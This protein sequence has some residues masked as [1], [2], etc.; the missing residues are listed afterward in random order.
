MRVTGIFLIMLVTL[1]PVSAQLPSRFLLYDIKDGL[2]QNSVHAIFRDR[3]GL[4]WIGTQDGLNS[5]DGKNFT[6]YRHSDDDS[7]SISDQFVL[8]IQEDRS[9][10]IW[11]GT[12]NGLNAFNKRTKKFRRY[13]ADEKERHEFQSTYSDIFIQPD[14]NILIKKDGLYSLNTV[15]GQCRPLEINSLKNI[16]WLIAAAGKA[17]GLDASGNLYCN[18]NYATKE[19]TVSTLFTAPV[20]DLSSYNAKAY[21]DSLLFIYSGTKIFIYDTRHALIR[22]E[23]DL[24]FTCYSLTVTGPDEIYACGDKGI[25]LGGIN[26]ITEQISTRNANGNILPPGT[27]LSAFRDA[28]AD[29]WIGTSGNGIAVSN[30]SFNNYQLIRSP[31]PNDAVTAITKSGNQLYMGTRSGLYIISGSSKNISSLLKEK[32][33]TALTVDT[34]GNIWAGIQG[35]GIIVIGKTGNIIKKISTGNDPVKNVVMNLCVNSKGMIAA[36]TTGGFFFIDPDNGTISSPAEKLSGTYVMSAFED[37]GKNIWVANNNG[38]DEFAEAGKKKA[39]FISSDD[40]SSFIKRTIITSVTQDTAGAIW[41]GTIR[42]GIYKY[43]H[44]NFSHYTVSAGLA[45]D[46]V[47][48]VSCDGQNRIWATTSAGLDIFNASKNSFTTLSP[49]DGIPAS[50]FVF[51]AIYNDGDHIYFGTSEGMI[52]CNTNDIILHETGIEGICCRCKSERTKY[53]Y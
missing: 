1:V 41:I 14:G 8:N 4:V 18:K 21:G 49:A 10:T 40:K 29:L 43:E 25:C 30:K 17:W 53:Q 15:T 44:G 50:G 45:S 22:K 32:S 3:D 51:G 27:V 48:N 28:E 36:S 12:R 42:N 2:S 47:Y 23:I 6:V 9:G 20:T 16:N 13:Y 46:V 34:K 39:S 26:R 52:I 31:V 11:I 35:E 33:I 5:F 38:L 24:P 7:T 19:I 37:R